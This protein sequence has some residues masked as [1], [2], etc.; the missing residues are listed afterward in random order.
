MTLCR[1][2]TKQFETVATMHSRE[3]AA[4]LATDPNRTR[5]EFVVVLHALAHEHAVASET[6][7]DAVLL[8]LID[9]QTA[10]VAPK[11]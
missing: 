1:E 11:S 8:P 9:A 10:P 2:L 6:V 3:L 7:H 4:W 5:G